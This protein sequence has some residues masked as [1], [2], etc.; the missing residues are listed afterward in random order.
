MKLLEL[1][2][3]RLLGRPADDEALCI[4]CSWLG[5]NVEVDVIDLLMSDTS[6]VLGKYSVSIQQTSRVCKD[7]DLQEVV[8]LRVQGKC[9]LLGRREDVR[10]VLVG[11]LM[12]FLRMI[13]V[14]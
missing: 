12:E 3:G 10:E 1:I 14:I 2:H 9:D 8:V 6:I 11:E 5:D 7:A 13:Y 4:A